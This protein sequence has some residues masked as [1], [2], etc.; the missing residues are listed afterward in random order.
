MQNALTHIIQVNGK[1]NKILYSKALCGIK[2]IC[3]K[4]L[5]VYVN[6]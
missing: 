2:A 6:L 4:S 1:C 3:I 5:K